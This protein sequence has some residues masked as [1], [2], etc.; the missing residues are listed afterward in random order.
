MKSCRHRRRCKVEVVDR[1]R[2]VDLEMDSPEAERRLCPRHLRCRALARAEEQ[3][4]GA[5]ADRYRRVES[6]LFLHRPLFLAV[7]AE[8]ETQRTVREA[9]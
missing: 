4:R 6:M 7:A 5:E 9:G 2:A 1:A 8:Q 3:A